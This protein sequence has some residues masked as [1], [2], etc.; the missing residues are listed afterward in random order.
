MAVDIETINKTVSSYVYDVKSIIPIDRVFLYGSYAKGVATAQSDIDI[1][2][3]S[4]AFEN[5]SPIE[6]MKQL[7]KCARKYK[8]IDIEP[9]GFSTSELENDNPFVK[10]VLRTGREIV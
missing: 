2:F 7:F 10:E 9:R 4:R 6:I 8:G 5:L 1:C 3:F